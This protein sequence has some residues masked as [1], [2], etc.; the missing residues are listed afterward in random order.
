MMA[1][2]NLNQARFNMIEQQIRPW[3]VLDQRVLDLMSEL[4]RDEFV[5]TA[6]RNLAFADIHIPLAHN[7]VMMPPKVEGRLLQSL[8]LSPTDR[9][10]EIGTGSGYLTALLAKSTKAVDSID[11]FSDFTEQATLKLK[12]LNINNVSLET[13]DAIN[14]WKNSTHY[15]VIVLTGSVPVLKSHFQSQL[16]NGGRLFAIVGEEPLMNAELIVRVSEKEWR[17]ESLFETTLPPLL[18]APTPSHFML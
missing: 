2:L 12:I 3:E 9:V 8:L 7:Q 15:D 18:G 17:C 1:Q 13:G 14:G 16:T 4:P 5:P 11:I 6:Y 10:L